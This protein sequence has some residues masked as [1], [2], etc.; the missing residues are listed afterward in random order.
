MPFTIGK[1]WKPRSWGM[2]LNFKKRIQPTFGSQADG[3]Q[4]EFQYFETPIVIDNTTNRVIE[5]TLTAMRR[6]SAG[7]GSAVES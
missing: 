1:A 4:A 7:V 3:S 6:A 2:D 5:A